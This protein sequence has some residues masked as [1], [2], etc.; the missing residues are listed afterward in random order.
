[1]DRI[2]I[3]SEITN[4]VDELREERDTLRIARDEAA[5]E[6]E[7]AR[8][9]SNDPLPDD[10]DEETAARDAED[11]LRDWES[12]NAEELAELE[13]L[14]DELRGYGG[15]H[16][17]EGDWYPRELIAEEDFAEY[18]QELAEE[19]GMVK[20]D[21]S[22]PNNCIDWDKA[23]DQLRQDYSMVTFRDTDYLYR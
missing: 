16:Q 17:W 14:L 5:T 6:L 9:L 7:D 3:E 20:D 18:A 13:A 19:C 21:A 10:C 4:R 15:D 2:D 1:M 23:A 11:A 8:A 12:D 22:W